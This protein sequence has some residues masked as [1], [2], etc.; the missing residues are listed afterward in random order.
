MTY[1]KG[2]AVTLDADSLA[3]LFDLEQFTEVREVLGED[4]PGMLDKFYLTLEEGI[5][6]IR[7]AIATQNGVALKRAAHKL[8][9][10]T[11]AVGAKTLS[12]FC[13]ELEQRGSESRFD[14]ATELLAQLSLD[15]VQVQAHMRSLS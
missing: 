4:F 12:A 13:T 3:R 11:A 2:L 1:N 10:A 7:A 5:D 14:G 6:G 15:Y 8:K 9:G